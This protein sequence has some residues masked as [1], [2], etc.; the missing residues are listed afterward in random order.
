MQRIDAPRGLIVPMVSP[1]L[2][3]HSV[4]AAAANR[5]VDHLVAAGVAGIFVLGTTGEARSMSEAQKLALVDCVARRAGD[6]VRLYAGISDNTPAA[7]IAAAQRYRDLG[8]HYAVAHPPTD[9]SVPPQAMT[10]YFAHLADR[11]TLPLVIYNIPKVAGVSIP[12]DTIAQSAHHAN[13]VGVKDSEGDRARLGL[14]LAACEPIAGFTVLVG[15]ANLSSYGLRHGAAGL[16]P[17]GANLIPRAYQLMIDAAQR[18]DWDAVEQ[19]QRT[20]D[21]V[22]RKY[23]RGRPLHESLAALKH[24]MKEEGLCGPA[25]VLPAR[26]P[27]GDPA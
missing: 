7:S 18:G 16:V 12:V 6:R 27:V 24:L 5:I 1:F 2:G 11:V 19:L 22:A 15:S 23:Q 14:L 13:I 21:N 8:A 10:D 4:D 3:D 25:V 17:S 9:G 26:Q 20:T